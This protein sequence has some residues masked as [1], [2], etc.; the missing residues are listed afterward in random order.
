MLWDRE[1]PAFI[2]VAP[3]A[4][5]L[6]PL[7][8]TFKKV[9]IKIKNPKSRTPPPKKSKKIVRGLWIYLHH[10]FF[11][12]NIVLRN[13]VNIYSTNFVLPNLLESNQNH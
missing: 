13:I 3:I 1:D 11:R 9:L 8:I 12:C 7:F 6:A 10:F 2:P 4:R 5:F